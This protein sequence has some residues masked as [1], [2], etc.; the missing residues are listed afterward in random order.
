VSP[1]AGSFVLEDGHHDDV[2]AFGAGSGIT[3]L[4]SIFK[5][6]LA[7]GERHFR[8]L[9]ANRDRA[10]AIFAD[11]LDELS[12]VHSDRFT[13]THRF[14]VAHG[15]VDCTTIADIL[16]CDSDVEI[17]VCGPAPFMDIV[18]TTLSTRS[19]PVERIHVER[20]TPTETIPAGDVDDVKIAIT[21]GRETKTVRHRANT[22]ILQSAKSAGLR[23]PSSCET[24]AC[25]TCMARV[26]EGRAH[27]RHDEALTADEIADGWILTCQALPVTPFVKVVYE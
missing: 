11:E 15:F 23:A 21:L 22:T 9:Y 16:S 24:G 6:G 18:Q 26:V 4:F 25:A 5:S 13:V 12:R 8:L 7:R 27:M 1:P 3:P 10:A 20:F 14:D 17:F 19:I 2:V